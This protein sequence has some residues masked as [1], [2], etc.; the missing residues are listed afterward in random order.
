MSDST[1]YDQIIF[2]A[3]HNSYDRDETLSEQLTF[4]ATDPSNC[5]CLALELDIWRHTS[6]YVPYESIDAGFFTVNHLTPG[7]TTLSSYLDQILLWHHDHSTHNA[8][9]ITLDIKSSNEGYDNFQ[10]QIDTYLKCYFDETLIFKPNKLMHSSHLDLCENVIH[11]GWPALTSSELKG[12]FIFCLSGNSEWKSEYARTNLS[13]RYCFSDEDKSDSDAEVHPP[14]SGNIVFFNFHIY[15]KNRSVWMNTIPPFA[16]NKLITRTYLSDDDTMWTNCIKANV[17]AIA[18]NKIS[19]ESW[20]KLSD[21]SEYT[22]KATSFDTRY[23][24]NKANQ[25]YRTNEATKMQDTFES[26]ECTFIFEPYTNGNEI[27]YALRNAYNNEYLDC[28]IRSMSRTVDGNC[29]KWQ[30]IVVNSSLSEY[31]VRNLEN[32][33]YLTRSA[34]QLSESAGTDEVYIIKPC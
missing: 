33:E 13:I 28:S 12:K 9:L 7:D 20:C 26:P 29:Q 11:S 31:Y 21:D 8:V 34:S 22:K 10:D 16:A 15:D 30:L 1:T 23:L 27:V 4:D 2:K 14:T 17:S 24:K 3:S 18:T 25:E 19:G 32:N 5:G 6:P